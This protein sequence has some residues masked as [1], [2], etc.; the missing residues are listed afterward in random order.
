MKIS[1]PPQRLPTSN[2]LNVYMKMHSL[3]ELWHPQVAKIK[4]F[5]VESIVVCDFP[6]MSLMQPLQQQIFSAP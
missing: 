6:W 3:L 4:I 2:Q 5:P 1:H